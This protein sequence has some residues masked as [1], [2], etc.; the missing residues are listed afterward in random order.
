MSRYTIFLGGVHGSGKGHFYDLMR[1]QIICDH[2]S[3]SSLLHWATKEKTVEDVDANQDLL[4]SLL[5]D[6]IKGDKAYLIDGHYALWNKRGGIDRVSLTVFEACKPDVLLCMTGNPALIAERLSRRDS[7]QYTDEQIAA[8]Q[9]EEIEVAKRISGH[10]QRPL[11]LMDTEDIEN[12]MAIIKEIKTAMSEYTRDNIYSEMLKTVIIRFDFSG[13]TSIRRFVDAIK[14]ES[15]IKDSFAELRLINQKQ[16]NIRV[17]PK[18]MEDGSLPVAERQNNIVYHFFDCKIDA[19]LEVVLDI[20]VDT[21]C[22]TIDCRKGYK[23]SRKYTDL[24]VKLMMKLKQVD[25]YISIQ[26][27]GVRK[28]DA[29]IIPPGGHISQYFNENYLAAASWYAS[30]KDSVNFAEM[31]HLGKVNYNVVQHIDRSSSNEDR[32]IYDVD[33]FIVNGEISSLMT[34]EAHLSTF[35]NE[36]VQDRMFDLFVSVAARDYLE[37]CKQAKQQQ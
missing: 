22:L 20:A 15:F 21:V 7:I 27:I 14:Q 4:A 29:Q 30:K 12:Q 32:V 36:E 26:R 1:E 23:G 18:E 2:V 19:G 33:A 28:I 35:L 3:A 37:K 9:S 13:S 31:F 24:M 8:L 10:L 11:Y 17:A 25:P 16:Y 34:D 5:P 6:A